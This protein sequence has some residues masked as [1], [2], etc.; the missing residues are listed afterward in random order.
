[1]GAGVAALT[2][3]LLVAGQAHAAETQVLWAMS[4]GTYGFEVVGLQSLWR[5]WLASST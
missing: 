2:V 3:K 5:A 4:R 1:M